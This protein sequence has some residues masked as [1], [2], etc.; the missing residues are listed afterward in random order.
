MAKPKSEERSIQKSVYFKESTWKLLEKYFGYSKVSANIER[1]LLRH[2][3]DPN[4]EKKAR[5][6]EIQQKL[7]EFN[8]VWGMKLEIREQ[9]EEPPLPPKEE[10]SDAERA[11][12][13]LQILR[14]G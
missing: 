11:E 13:D 9:E 2:L 4:A 5:L 3:E 7:A 6:A 14:G 1:I 10:G 12:R 8:G